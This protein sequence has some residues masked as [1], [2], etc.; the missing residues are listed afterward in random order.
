MTCL[1]DLQFYRFCCF[2]LSYIKFPFQSCFSW[3]NCSAAIDPWWLHKKTLI[4]IS[5]SQCW[6]FQS[7]WS[8]TCVKC[9]LLSDMTESAWSNLRLYRILDQ[10]VGADGSNARSSPFIGIKSTDFGQWF[11]SIFRDLA[12]LFTGFK[13]S[14]KGLCSHILLTKPFKYRF[15]FLIQ[16]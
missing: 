15:Q 6:S 16:D 3:D 1:L 4:A 8:V 14:L 9:C 2:I 7:L 12:Y 5:G 10:W 13:H 11:F